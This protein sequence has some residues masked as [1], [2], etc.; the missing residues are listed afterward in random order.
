MAWAHAMLLR[1]YKILYDPRIII[2]HSHNRPPE[3]RFKRSIASSIACAKILG[4]VKEDISCLSVSD[5]VDITDN[6]KNFSND[7]KEQWVVQSG[8]YTQK[9]DIARYYLMARKYVPFLKKVRQ[10][11]R[12]NICQSEENTN[13]LRM[14]QTYNNHIRFVMSMITGRYSLPSV[15]DYAYCVDQ[16]TATTL[17]MLYG[18][19]YAGHILKGIVPR[20]VKEL[21][22]PYIKGV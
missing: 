16:V 6:L 12:K 17:G 3:Y 15:D 20:E 1:G 2:S 18:E 14:Q 8:L 7:L 13:S 21:V 9:I 10:L 4:R 5:L 11:L 22:R 19:L